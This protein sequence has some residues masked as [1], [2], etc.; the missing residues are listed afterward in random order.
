M[1]LST[2]PQSKI[3]AGKN[4]TNRHEATFKRGSLMFIEGETSAEMFILRSGKV[5]ILK[6]EGDNTLELAVL[7][8][9]SV[10]G[11]LSLLDHQP[12]GATAQVLDDL[13]ATII[14]EEH[15]QETL[16]KIPTWMNSIVS[17][18]VKRLRDT[19]KKTT[20]DVIRKSVAGV[21]KVILLLRDSHGVEREG[22]K[23][24]PVTL[25]KERIYSVIGLGGLEV[26]NVFLH[27]ILKQMLFIQKNELGQEFLDCPDPEILLLYMNYLRSHQRNAAI[28]G[29]ALSAGSVELIG[30]L[31]SATE[32]SGRRVKD[33]VFQIGIPQVELELER[34]GKGRFVNL[35]ALDELINGKIIMSQ[36][37]KTESS[38]GTHKR[39]SVV[40]NMDS[41]KRIQTLHKWLSTFQEDVQ[42]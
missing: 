13:V 27:L 2:T 35:D 19:M 8:P 9:G 40:Y 29:E 12:R 4:V 16:K 21:I 26:E 22:R 31:L 30:L 37:A 32:K 11:E 10:L 23:M 5:R 34:Q 28:M 36:E 33:N 18:V 20:D 24:V 39:T 6:Q 25:A 3:G 15:L 1:T 38:F 42:F 7:G 41:L 17:A 14:D